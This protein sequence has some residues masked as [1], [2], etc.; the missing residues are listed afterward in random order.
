MTEEETKI[1]QRYEQAVRNLNS[2]AWE[3]NVMLPEEK[4]ADLQAIEDYN[5]Y[6]NERVAADVRM[7]SMK[8]GEYGYAYG[9]DIAV[10]KEAL[11]NA[12]YLENV[13]TVFHE[14]EHVKQYQANYIPEVR[15]QY[16]EEE[17]SAINEP[18][19]DPDK[20]YEK[21][22]NSPAEIVARKAGQEGVEQV[23]QDREAILEADQE[24]QMSRGT[25]NQI[26]ETHDYCVLNQE[27]PN[28]Y[29][30]AENNIESGASV[31]ADQG[32]ECCAQEGMEMGGEDGGG[33]DGP[34]IGDD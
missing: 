22:F 21:Y 23:R 4:V 3:N 28:V 13:D 34:G 20:D 17:L 14:S 19:P 15:A 25:R 10:S 32:M 7:E 33:M 27:A 24:Y 31:Q 12:S 2:R 5:A 29:A 26:L 11:E 8:E 1:T 6:R 16:T 30:V 18:I 9:M